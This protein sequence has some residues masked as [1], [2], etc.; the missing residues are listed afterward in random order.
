MASALTLFPDRL[1]VGQLTLDQPVVVRIH[2]REPHMRAGLADRLSFVI[3]RFP[4]FPLSRIDAAPPQDFRQS[5]RQM[6]Q[7][8]GEGDEAQTV[9]CGPPSSPR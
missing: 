5:H 9:C 6:E 4:A 2:V 8:R 3:P 7:Q 1:M